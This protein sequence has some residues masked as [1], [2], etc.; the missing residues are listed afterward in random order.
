[1]DVQ[2]YLHS[3]TGKIFK[4]LPMYESGDETVF[5]YME[6][7]VAELSGGSFSFPELGSDASYIS[8]L[9]NINFILHHECSV[10]QCKREVFNMLSSIDNLKEKYR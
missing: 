10:D 3:L 6:H 7:L 8:V 9:N 4:I 2:A 1:M 5:I